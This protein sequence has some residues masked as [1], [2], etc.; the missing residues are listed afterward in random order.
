MFDGFPY[1]PGSRNSH[2]LVGADLTGVR[3]GL[4]RLLPLRRTTIVEFEL[5]TCSY[6]LLLAYLFGGGLQRYPLLFHVFLYSAMDISGY[7]QRQC[8]AFRALRL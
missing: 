8:C 5:Y 3:E 1:V 6:L 7:H 4:N 2:A